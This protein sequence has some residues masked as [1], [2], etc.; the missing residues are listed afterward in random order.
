MS[1]VTQPPPPW[2]AFPTQE[3]NRSNLRIALEKSVHDRRSVDLAVSESEA[4]KAR[5]SARTIGY[6]LGLAVRT[7]LYAH[8]EPGKVTLRVMAVPKGVA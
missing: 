7:R 5:A 2:T 8:P 3:R 4:D 6:K 1:A